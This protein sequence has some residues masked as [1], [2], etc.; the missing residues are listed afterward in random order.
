MLVKTGCY[1]ALS[2]QIHNPAAKSS[3]L[4]R[5]GIIVKENYSNKEKG[6]DR[7]NKTQNKAVPKKI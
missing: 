5:E 7:V 3:E 4:Y 1:P 2:L 6:H